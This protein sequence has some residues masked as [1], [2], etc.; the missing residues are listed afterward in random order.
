MHENINDHMPNDERAIPF[1]NILYIG[2]GLTDVPCMTVIRKNGGFAIAVFRKKDK[3][4]KNVCQELL[5]AERVDFIA[6][7]DY[8]NDTELDKLIKL[9]LH[10]MYEGIRYGRVSSQQAHKHLKKKGG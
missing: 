1:Q 2:D 4:G 9:I 6:P 8:N 7:A 10:N 5:R 3:D